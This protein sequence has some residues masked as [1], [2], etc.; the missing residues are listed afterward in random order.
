MLANMSSTDLF[1][2]TI[3]PS[4]MYKAGVV[5]LLDGCRNNTFRLPHVNTALL[6][7][8][9]FTSSSIQSNRNVPTNACR[10]VYFSLQ[11]QLDPE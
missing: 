11:V 3:S 4:L 2:A 7:I 8:A 10:Q 6:L 1:T 9:Y 5:L